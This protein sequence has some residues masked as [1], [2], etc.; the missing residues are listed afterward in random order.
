M[1]NI[2]IHFL[3]TIWSD[4][5][6]L[7]IDDHYAFVDT[8]TDFYY[9]MIQK[10]LGDLNIK[11][12][13]FILL[14]HFHCDH[15]GCIANL[16][17]DYKV[18]KLYLKEYF[19]LEGSSSGGVEANESYINN[20]QKNYEIILKKAK[21]NNTDIIYIDKT[22]KD[23][24][25][26]DFYGIDIE[27]YNIKNDLYDIY[28]DK[29]NPYYNQRAFGENFNSIGVFFMVNDYSILLAA[30]L[31]C[32]NNE[33][34]ILDNKAIKLVNNIYKRHNIDHID[35]FKSCH[36]GHT[37]NNPFELLKLVK[38]NYTIITNTNK[39]VDNF[40]ICKDLNKISPHCDILLTDYH[41][42]IFTIDEKI[43]YQTIE[44]V[45]LFIILEKE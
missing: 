32:E 7:Q 8:G 27:I 16:L 41:K 4:A 25:I 11:K 40:T 20:Q 1:K 29:N 19:A 6:I 44:D 39:W 22:N 14:T 36:H 37:H 10:H 45:S 3:N 5:I 13:D 34:D 23:N 26:I 15:Y 35:I 17:N 18:D 24:Y 9:P 2:K 38:P 31:T 30:D 21:E 33:L 42:Y 28:N 43:N 12:I